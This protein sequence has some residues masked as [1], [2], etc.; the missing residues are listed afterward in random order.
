MN[1]Q[2]RKACD[3]YIREP[4]SKRQDRSERRRR[5]ACL[6]NYDSGYCLFI[7]WRRKAVEPVASRILGR[8]G[9]KHRAFYELEAIWGR[10]IFIDSSVW[11]GIMW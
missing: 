6:H 4:Y 8:S 9:G 2:R 3:I 1:R 5:G 10:M 11:A 7:I